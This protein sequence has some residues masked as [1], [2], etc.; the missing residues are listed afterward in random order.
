MGNLN[1]TWLASYFGFQLFEYER[2]GDSILIA[3]GSG[4][5]MAIMDICPRFKWC[6]EVDNHRDIASRLPNLINAFDQN[7]SLEIIAIAGW[8][9]ID[10]P[11]QLMLAQDKIKQSKNFSYSGGYGFFKNEDIDLEKFVANINYG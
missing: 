3:S 1:P 10:D 5:M 6:L 8:F 4:L 11:K 7:C 9:S 2:Q